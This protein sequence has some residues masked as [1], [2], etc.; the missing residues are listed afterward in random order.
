MSAE[1]PLRVL[2][3]GGIETRFHHFDE[4][5]PALTAVIAAADRPVTQLLAPDALR[6]E[7]LQKFDA[8]VS[9]TT[10][11]EL[12]AAQE[13]ALL[14]ASAEPKNDRGLPLHFL[15]VHGASC[16]FSSSP[17]YLAMLGGQF[18]RHAPMATFRVAID[19]PDHP[20]TRGVSAFDIHDELYVL[21][22]RSA[23]RVLLSAENPEPGAPSAPRLPLGWVRQHGQG[24][25]CYVALGHGPEQL[26]HPSV[27]RLITQALAWFA[28]STG[29]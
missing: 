15:G 7:V 21:E 6:P 1:A 25:V 27:V 11:G 19:V 18:L 13:D 23:V 29:P 16:S 12:T 9:L 2:V 8:L 20:V 4:L 10:G 3:M 5:G 14:T 28:T 26:S 22:L 24:R 17:R